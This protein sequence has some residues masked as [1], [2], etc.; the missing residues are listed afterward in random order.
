MSVKKQ[1]PEDGLRDEINRPVDAEALH[2]AAPDPLAP[3]G[4]QILR[5]EPPSWE[6]LT[7]ILAEQA[8]ISSYG[9]DGWELVS[10]TSHG[11]NEATYYF[12]RPKA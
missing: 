12:K 1:R 4:G 6:Y 2:H 8:D 3:I 10:V 5:V 7:R 9:A 11:F